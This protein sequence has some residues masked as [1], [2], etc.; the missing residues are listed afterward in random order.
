V[1]VSENQSCHASLNFGKLARYVISFILCLLDPVML[2]ITLFSTTFGPCP[3]FFVRADDTQR[4]MQLFHMDL[5]SAFECSRDDLWLDN[6]SN[7]WEANSRSASQEI[8][9]IS[10]L[11]GN[12]KVHYCV[13]KS[14]PVDLI[15]RHVNPINILPHYFMKSHFNII[16]SPASRSSKWSLPIKF[17]SSKIVYAFLISHK[18]ATCPANLIALDWIV[19]MKSSHE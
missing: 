17:L 10:R 15:P 12:P 16:L 14:P 11:W 5:S 4:A 3:C 7:T 8:P 13:H 19:L 2:F 6:K 9:Q 18:R 1:G